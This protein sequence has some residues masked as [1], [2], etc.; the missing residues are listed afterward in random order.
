M[1]RDRILLTLRAVCRLAN[2][3]AGAEDEAVAL[4]I[5]AASPRGLHRKNR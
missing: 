3:A 5:A 1:Q 2:S 4:G